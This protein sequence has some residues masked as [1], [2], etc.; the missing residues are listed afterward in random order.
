MKTTTRGR[1]GSIVTGQFQC[2]KTVGVKMAASVVVLAGGGFYTGFSASLGYT[3]SLRMVVCIGTIGNSNCTAKAYIN[4]SCIVTVTVGVSTNMP[5][6]AG[7][8][9]E[10]RASYRAAV[11]VNANI[12]IGRKCTSNDNDQESASTDVSVSES[13]EVGVAVHNIINVSVVIF[14]SV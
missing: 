14:E 7:T 2:R 10:D 12:E 11:N 1:I 6:R 4:E 5:A 8:V 13:V 9:D 3:I